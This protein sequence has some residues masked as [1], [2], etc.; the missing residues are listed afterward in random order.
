MAK[1]Q[2]FLAGVFSRMGR[3]IFRALS[4]WEECS[5]LPGA[6]RCLKLTLLGFFVTLITSLALD[7]REPEVTCY[8]AARLP[9]VV[10][11][12]VSV[13]PNPTKGA[14]S[15]TLRASAKVFDTSLKD[16]YISDAWLL[17]QKDTTRIPVKAVDGRFS[18]TLEMLEGHL[19]VGDLDTG[20]S[21]IS[22]VV[23]TSQGELESY[24]TEFN[25]SEPD[26]LAADSTGTGK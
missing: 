23:T 2:N 19:Y 26:S 20:L 10:F 4:R 1:A 11:T 18:D 15:V 16:N 8:I 12:D 9:E 13:S 5:F 21:W 7:A 24:W 22:L 17:R 14:D 3:S 6:A 25:V